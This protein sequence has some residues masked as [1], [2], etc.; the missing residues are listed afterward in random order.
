MLSIEEIELLEEMDKSTPIEEIAQK[1]R[2]SISQAKKLIEN[3][4]TKRKNLTELAREMK[5]PTSY[6]R[7]VDDRVDVIQKGTMKVG[8][9]ILKHLSEGIYSSPAGS[10]KELISNAFDSDSPSVDFIISEDEVIVKDK[11]HGMNWKD[12]DEDFTFISR[13]MKR[14]ISDKTELYNRP[15]IGFLG[16]GF[17]S[18]SELCDTMIIKSCKR[19]DDKFFIA[20]IDFSRYRETKIAEK[21]FYEVSEYKLTNYYKVK[22]NIPKETSFTEIKLRNLRS[23]FKKILHDRQPFGKKEASVMELQKY[24]SSNKI[25]IT[26]LGQYWQMIWEIACMAPIPYYESSKTLGKID[27]T[28]ERINQ[29]LRSFNFMVT[30]NGLELVKPFK[31]PLSDDLDPDDYRIHP[32]REKIT[33]S[34]GNLSFKGYI[35]SQHGIIFPK[36]YIGLLIRIKNVAIGPID[37][38]LLDYPSSSNQLFRNWIFGEIYVEEGLEDAINI[39]RNQFKITDPNYIALRTWLHNFL[40]NEIFPYTLHEYY[41]KASA[42]R[43]EERRIE[44][45][46]KLVKITESEMGKE[47]SFSYRFIPENQPLKINKLEKTIIV[48]SGY[49]FYKLDKKLRPILQEMF[50]LFEIAVEKSNGDVEKL[51]KS[52]REEIERWLR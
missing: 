12:F 36:E 23:G 8:S 39:N 45:M 28:I 2:V 18:V 49:P 29:T 6:I 52:F 33:T 10:L 15:I 34:K 21:E 1:L 38:S 19:N 47:Y 44:N 46:E 17:I 7:A 40:N 27:G 13:S 14:D 11:G 5:I 26:N 43:A 51:K 50:L 22:Y 9:Q 35:Y 4:E 16:I 3:A 48:N 41:Q 37:R 24:I 20:E 30:I 42:E 32:I 31:F 25:G